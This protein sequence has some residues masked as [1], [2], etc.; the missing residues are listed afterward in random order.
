LILIP[1]GVFQRPA[2]PRP[3][4]RLL[5]T[6]KLGEKSKLHVMP[7]LQGHDSGVNIPPAGLT[8]F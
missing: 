2:K 6:S 1:V 3:S 4:G 5:K 8:L 7:E